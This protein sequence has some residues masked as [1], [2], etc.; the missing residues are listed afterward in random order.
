MDIAIIRNYATLSPISRGTTT[1]INVIRP[2]LVYDE[3][4]T[5]KYNFNILRHRNVIL[6]ETLPRNAEFHYEHIQVNTILQTV[7]RKSRIRS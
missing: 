7:K 6:L 5:Q 1:Y 4:T 2:T 3:S